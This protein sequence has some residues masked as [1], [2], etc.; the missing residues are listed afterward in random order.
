ML[1]FDDSFPNTHKHSGRNSLFEVEKFITQNF[2]YTFTT[3]IVGRVNLMPENHDKQLI[4]RWRTNNNIPARTIELESRKS[5]V[6]IQRGMN[7]NA[8]N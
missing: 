1:E 8:D 5:S 3:R 6:Q 4:Q 7:G 2:H